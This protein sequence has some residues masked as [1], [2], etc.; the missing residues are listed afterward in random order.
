MLNRAGETTR[1]QISLDEIRII[2]GLFQLRTVTRAH[3]YNRGSARFPKVIIE[4][5]DKVQFLLKRRIGTPANLARVRLSHEVQLELARKGF[6]TAPL[7]RSAADATWILDEG[8]LYEMFAFIEGDRF[9]R[10]TWEARE[11]GT[12]LLRL[13]RTLQEWHPSTPS[14]DHFGYHN[15]KS[16]ASSWDILARKILEVNPQATKSKLERIIEILRTQYND[17]AAAAESVLQASATYGHRSILHGDFH[18]GNIL[19]GAGTPVVMLDFD[20]TRVDRTIF[21]IANAALQFSIPS[22]SQKSVS[23]WDATLNVQ[24]IESFLSGYGLST[25]I[26]LN[27]E[28]CGALSSLM[29]EATIAETI[30][31]IALSGSWEGRSGIEILRFIALRSDWILSQRERLTKLFQQCMGHES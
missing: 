18:P 19:F 12:M 25:E 30:P 8:C 11:S 31:R 5:E 3:A 23:H 28:E 16:V 24:L 6:P 14:P 20:S 27:A 2:A 4:T 15:S 26:E 21:D 17:A 29:I 13:H 22:M 9:R 10:S 7:M 1:A